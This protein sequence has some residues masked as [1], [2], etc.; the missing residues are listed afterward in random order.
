MSP[1]TYCKIKNKINLSIFLLFLTPFFLQAQEELRDHDDLSNNDILFEIPHHVNEDFSSGTYGD[2][3]G[4]TAVELET[5]LEAP[6]V[7]CGQAA[8]FVLNSAGI[9]YSGS[10]FDY[11]V[12]K[13]WL[14]NA[15]PGNQIS[16]KALSFLI[17]KAFSIKGDIMYRLFPGPRYAYRSMV[18]LSYIQGVSDPSMKISGDRF[19][20]ILGNVLTAQG[21]GQ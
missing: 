15:A 18:S 2:F 5:V 10:S 17:M 7:T 11:A 13:G 14:K 20:L 19:L 21:E 6:A 9:D 12:S 3:I 4:S 16:M 8:M 1:H